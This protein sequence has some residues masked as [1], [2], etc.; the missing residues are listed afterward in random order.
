MGNRE[1]ARHLFA[2]LI[3]LGDNPWNGYSI[4]IDG[5]FEK[6]VYASSDQDAIKQFYDW[7]EEKNK[8]SS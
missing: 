5:Y 6:R 7:V 4:L 3:K 1:I 2:S 8:K